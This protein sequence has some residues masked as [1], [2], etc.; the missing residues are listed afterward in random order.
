MKIAIP[1]ENGKISPHFGRCEE[2]VI[3]EIE[4]GKI[5]NKEIVENTARG[6]MHGVGTTAASIVGNYNVDI[7]IVQNIGPKAYDVFK[8]L[9]ID[10]YKCNT[11]SIDECVKLFLEGKLE[12]FE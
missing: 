9:G 1:T 3:V 7:L 6:G 10:V 4:D 11:S 2:F 12:K 8:K 5:K